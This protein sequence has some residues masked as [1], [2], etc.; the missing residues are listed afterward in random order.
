MTLGVC[1]ESG[2]EDAGFYLGGCDGGVIGD[3]VKR[4]PDDLKRRAAVIPFTCDAG[5]H[6]GERFYDPVHR[7]FLNRRIA[8]EGAGEI[9][10]GKDAGDQTRCRSGIAAVKHGIRRA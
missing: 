5:A 4:L 3:A 10:S 8:G 6:A 2:E 1:V 7:A 9:L